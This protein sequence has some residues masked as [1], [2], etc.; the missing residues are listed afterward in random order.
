MDTIAG[1]VAACYAQYGVAGVVQVIARIEP[2]GSVSAAYAQGD[3]ARTQT[4]GCVESAVLAASFPA[5]DGGSFTTQQSFQL[6]G[7][8]SNTKDSLREPPAPSAAPTE[9]ESQTPPAD[10]PAPDSDSSGGTQ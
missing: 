7:G 3:F 8:A 5:F 1:Q 6:G 10:N 9:P 2:N 4:G